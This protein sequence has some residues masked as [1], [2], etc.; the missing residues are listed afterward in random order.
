MTAPKP[1]MLPSP[2]H[3]IT[4]TPTGARVVV[5]AG[6][7]V[8]ADTDA[9]LTLAESTYPPVQYIPLADVD[10]EVLLPSATETYCPFKGEAS[11][12]GVATGSGEIKDAIWFYASP[13]DAVSEIAGH[14]AFYADRVEIS[15]GES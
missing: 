14:V 4:I 8:I 13:F 7:Q 1:V 5:R 11:Y 15:V 2:D 3:P 12:Y 10:A 6:E 9:A